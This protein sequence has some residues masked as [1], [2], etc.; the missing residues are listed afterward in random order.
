MTAAPREAAVLIVAEQP[1]ARR[2][3][4][5]RRRATASI[6]KRYG[7]RRRGEAGSVA[8]EVAIA[9]PILVAL[10]VFA[11]VLVS[12][13]VD[14]RLRLDDVAHQAARAASATRSPAAATTAAQQTVTASL[15]SA[16]V[17]CG[18]PGV[19]V[20]TSDFVPGGTVT[21]TVS[22][23][24][25]LSDAAALL[26]V[27]N[28]RTLTATATSP[29]DVYRAVSLGFAITDARSGGNRPAGVSV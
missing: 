23:R 18:R 22:C 27:G 4:V 29:L 10:L 21:V 1:D 17:D 25:D 9:V 20:D 5:G 2:A 26:A 14:A 3:V 28:S 7:E 15:A 19:S 16:G 13:G 6:V 12:R 11:G 8:A 24:L